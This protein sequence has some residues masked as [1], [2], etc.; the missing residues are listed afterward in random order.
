MVEPAGWRGGSSGD[1]SRAVSFWLM[2]KV[3]AGNVKLL[4]VAPLVAGADNLF[5]FSLLLLLFAATT[6]F[7]VRNPMRRTRFSPLPRTSRQEGRCSVRRA[8][9][10]QL[11]WC[12][13]PGDLQPRRS[14]VR[15]EAFP[16]SHQKTWPCKLPGTKGGQKLAADLL[17]ELQTAVVN[18]AA[19]RGSSLT[20]CE[21]CHE[22]R[23]AAC[24]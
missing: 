1:V 4:A 5:A 6:A 20:V 18:T 13:S 10:C 11:D 7:L 24:L 2:C 12:A 22:S 14:L 17:N 15:A 21:I 23:R 8:D 16:I 9:L 19:R 3:G